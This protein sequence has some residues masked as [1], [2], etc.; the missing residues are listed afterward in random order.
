MTAPRSSLWLRTSARWSRLP[1]RS[2]GASGQSARRSSRCGEMGFCLRRAGASV[3]M[4]SVRQDRLRYSSPPG[5]SGRACRRSGRP[6]SCLFSS[7]DA[8]GMCPPLS[9]RVAPSVS[10]LV[11]APIAAG[12]ARRPSP[13]RRALSAAGRFPPPNCR[14][15]FAAAGSFS[16]F[17][18]LL[19]DPLAKAG[20]SAKPCS[21]RAARRD[22]IL[23][24]TSESSF[25][26]V[27]FLSERQ[28]Q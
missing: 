12:F 5:A 23:P 13:C 10:S 21:V 1:A 7:S 27:G 2:A 28:Q 19:M 4:N 25:T 24:I 8:V 14:R 3:D 26:A 20:P 6:L 22:T 11:G 18:P 15:W 16:S 9:P 17:K